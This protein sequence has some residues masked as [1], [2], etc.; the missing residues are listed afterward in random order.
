MTHTQ[1]F[2]SPKSVFLGTAAWGIK[3]GKDEAYEIVGTFYRKGFQWVDTSTNYP[4]NQKPENYGQTVQWLS[5]F[6]SDFPKLKV[7]VKVGSATN[8]GDPAQL[9]NVSYLSLIH[10]LLMAQLGSNFGGLGIHWDNNIEVANQD[11]VVDFFSNINETGSAIGMSGISRLENYSS[12]SIA[13]QLPWVFQINLSPIRKEQTALEVE[14]VRHNFPVASIFGYNLLG[15]IRVNGLLGHD[16]RLARNSRL[17]DIPHS[18]SELSILK[19]AISH[20]LSLQVQGVI[21]GPTSAQQ[22]SGWCDALGKFSYA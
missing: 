22:C 19:E 13:K 12:S 21:I 7:Y 11:G 20:A 6:S 16:T 17:M 14:K 2:V 4:I 8:Q 9:I 10:N 3:V 5:E 18:K 1:S 15:G